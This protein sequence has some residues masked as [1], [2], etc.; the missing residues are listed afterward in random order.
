MGVFNGMFPVQAGKE[1]AAR[2][3]A[4]E[5]VG[6]R[7]TDYKAQLERGGITRETWALQET[8]MGSFM[9]VWFEGDVEKVFTE[10]ATDQSEFTTWF[11]AQ[12]LDVTGVDLAAPPEGPPPAILVDWS[13]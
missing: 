4:A 5:T 13:A 10:L 7:L 12:V 8:P 2:A 3:F 1:E 6:A 11:R 9:I